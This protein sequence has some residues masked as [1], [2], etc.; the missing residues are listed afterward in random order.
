MISSH[1]DTVDGHKR[2][3]IVMKTFHKGRYVN[4]QLGSTVVETYKYS[5]YSKN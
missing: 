3:N 4:V 5:H 1:N 2:T